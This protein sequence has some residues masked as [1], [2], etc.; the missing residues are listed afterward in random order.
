MSLDSLDDRSVARVRRLEIIH[1]RVLTPSSLYSFL[2]LA[3][4]TW[5]DSVY[6]QYAD[7]GVDLIK[8]DCI[9]AGN[10]VED[11]IK[12]VSAA[13]A[14]T[15]R[16]TVYS[17]SPGGGQPA[18]EFKQAQVSTLVPSTHNLFCDAYESRTV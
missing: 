17:L 18:A 7:W 8:N 6:G 11:N 16:P 10:Y 5:L 14:K 3:A 4:Q 15:G 1:L 12:G 2:D 13:I 9:F